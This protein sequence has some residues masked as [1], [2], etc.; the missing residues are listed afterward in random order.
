M[1][2]KLPDLPYD[3]S[4][5][6]PYLTPETF[7]FHHGKHHNA[8]VNNLNT[9][10]SGHALADLEVP[11]LLKRIEEVDASVRTKVFNN[12]AQHFNHSFYWNSLRPAS[13]S[14]PGGSFLEAVNRAFGSLDGL[15][16]A[17]TKEATLHFGSGW[18]WLVKDGSGALKVVST[19]DAGTPLTAGQTPLLT[20]DVWEHAYYIDYRND[21]AAY[22]KNFWEI[23]HWEFAERNWSAK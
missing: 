20:C 6:A 17:F 2:H 4:A 10:L 9:L 14:G 23:A 19:H 5:L 3:K 11:A 12:A 8:Y 7:N 1:A 21:R 13:K 18:A 22:L 16:D 15:K